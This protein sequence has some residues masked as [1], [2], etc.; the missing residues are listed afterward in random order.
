[1]SAIRIADQGGGGLRLQIDIS[2]LVDF[3]F[4]VLADPYRVVF[5]F[6]TLK[7]QVV[8][9]AGA[10]G[11]GQ[12]MIQGFRFGRFQPTISRLVLDVSEPVEVVRAVMAGP[13]GA[14]PARL[15]VELRPSDRASF[16]ETM[17]RMAPPAAKSNVAA[18]P[19]PAARVPGKDRRKVIVLDPGHGGVDPGATGVS[20]VFEKDLTLALA[21][22]LRRKL[23]ATGRYRVVMTR[24]GDEFISLGDR[25]RVG[26]EAHGDLFISIHAD[27]IS[28]RKIRGGTVYTLSQTA[29]DKEAEALATKENKA[30]II[31]GIDLGGESDV[32]TSILIDL[33]QRETMNH[34]ASFAQ[35]L[36]KELGRKILMHKNGHR[37]AGFRV[38]KAPD[39]PSVLIEIGYLSSRQDEDLLR[40]DLGRAKV[41]DAV[42]AGI[43][44][45][46]AGAKS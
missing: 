12:G 23:L 31:A 32:V 11:H 3:H 8:T 33:A 22:E 45:Y 35:V 6:P 17:R 29:S 7:W 30:D 16:L 44:R 20:G 15:T 40:T 41:A 38:L 1:M 13:Q 43:D 36:V 39:V 37:F 24:D 46:F 10:G 27:A 2:Q 25:V 34:S 19:Q 5:D 26:R 18:V 21:Q 42:V 14:A 9:G 4:F 28:D